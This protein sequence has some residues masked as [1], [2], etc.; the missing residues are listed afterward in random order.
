MSAG[1]G[2]SDFLRSVLGLLLLLLLFV[3]RIEAVLLLLLSSSD[4]YADVLLYESV[5]PVLSF[6]RRVPLDVESERR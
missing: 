5:E 6:R 4:E 1:G 2:W 3:L